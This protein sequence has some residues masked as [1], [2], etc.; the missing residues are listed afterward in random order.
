[1]KSLIDLI[2]RLFGKAPEPLKTEPVVTNEVAAKA[3]DQADR[4]GWRNRCCKPQQSLRQSLHLLAREGR[5]Y[6]AYQDI[7]GVWTICDGHNKRR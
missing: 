7:V 3:G 1:M 6:V 4:K 2:L 5:R